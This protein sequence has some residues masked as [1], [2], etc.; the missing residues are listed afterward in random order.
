MS[1]S[2]HSLS[3]ELLIHIF[4][5]LPVTDLFSVQTTCRRIYDIIAETAYLQY[6]LHSHLNGVDD[7]LPPNCPF[8]E[9]LE[10]LRH[11]EKAWNNLQFNLYSEISTNAN[12]YSR[13]TIIQDGY[14]IYRSNTDLTQYG[15]IDLFSLPPPNEEPRWV[16]I[17]LKNF[18]VPYAL[19]FF[20]DYDLVVAIREKG[21]FNGLV[22][23]QLA[24]FEFTT[25]APH[26]LSATHTMNVPLVDYL[27]SVRVE[28]EVIGDHILA[29]A[30]H[31]HGRAS[32]YLIS[33]KTGTVTFLRGLPGS[34]SLTVIDSDL[35]ML[36]REPVNCLEIYKLE[37]ASPQPRMRSVCTLGLPPLVPEAFI[38][39][40]TFAKEW[41]SSPEHRAR[42]RFSQRRHL[43]FRSSRNDTMA[44]LLSYYNPES[45]I[46]PS[47]YAVLF[48][49]TALLSLVHS[50]VRKV[51]WGKWGPLRT[52]IFPYLRAVKPTPAGPFWIT[53]FQPLIVRDYDPLR[54][55]H[56]RSAEDDPSLPSRLP[57]FAPAKVVSEN[58][59]SGQVETRLPY[60]EFV[61]KDIVI[62]NPAEIVGDREWVVVISATLEGTSYTVYHVG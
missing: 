21:T 18:L 24:F 49:V 13:K 54:V 2:L 14:L 3:T 25:G 44:L 36:M 17:S 27:G 34:P 19:V 43:P 33:W 11:H 10:L 22:L 16:H 26:P 29:K 39:D 12:Y 4:A 5:Y 61:S 6:I 53:S 55:V 42:S 1:C 32:F 35:I 46:H 59:V 56:V 30:V 15:Y 38:F 40:H 47:E 8:S 45:D 58:W 20:V 48:S 31:R 23:P 9:R 37:L 7:L 52:R 51:P 57:V 60:R 50:G 62:L 41:I 28:V